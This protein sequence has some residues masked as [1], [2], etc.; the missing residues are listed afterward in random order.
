MTPST[1]LALF[2]TTTL[3]GCILSFACL[4]WQINSMDI[5]FVLL[6]SWLLVGCFM[7]FVNSI[8]MNALIWC[9]I[10]E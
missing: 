7:L 5:D 4:P 10:C 1:E 8:A 9:D 6:S 2:T 3:S